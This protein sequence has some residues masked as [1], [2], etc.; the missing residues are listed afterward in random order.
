MRRIRRMIGK[1]R[2]LNRPGVSLPEYFKYKKRKGSKR[3]RWDAILS[4]LPANMPLLGVEIGILNGNTSHR[5]LRQRPLLKLYMVDPWIAP[6]EGS[7]YFKTGDDN[8]RKPAQ[9]HDKAYRLTLKRIEFAGDRAMIMRMFS[10][11]AEP[12]I[13][14]GSLD[15]VFIDGD[16]SYVGVSK[17]IKLW[18]PKIKKGGWIGGHD[19]QH[20]TRLNLQGVTIAVDEVFAKSKIE[21]DDN[22]TWFVRI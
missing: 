19:Y 1:R 5:I 7:S 15:F 14:N 8:A 2:N 4:R 12:K 11:E 20:E 16:H 3:K 6:E 13:E 17:D 22:H 18:L 9:E 10:H 21:I